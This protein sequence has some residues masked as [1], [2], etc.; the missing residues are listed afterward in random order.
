MI[1]VDYARQPGRFDLATEA[2]KAQLAAADSGEGSAAPQEDRTGDFEGAF[3]R[4]AKLPA[5]MNNQSR[6]RQP[7]HVSLPDEP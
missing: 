3:A 1:R 5:N 4:S 2:P 7:L 6:P